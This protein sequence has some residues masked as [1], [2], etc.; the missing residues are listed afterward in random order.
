MIGS[1]R[2]VVHAR[3]GLKKVGR[4]LKQNLK[5]QEGL[6]NRKTVPSTINAFVLECGHKF[7]ALKLWL[8]VTICL[9]NLV[10]GI[11]LLAFAKA[12]RPI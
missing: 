6:I 1:L 11:K 9:K 8:Q 5:S 3:C 4:F 10:D 2:K 7:C 12:V